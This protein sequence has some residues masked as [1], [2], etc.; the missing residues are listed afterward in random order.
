MRDDSYQC[1][2]RLYVYEL[3]DTYRDRLKHAGRGVG[4]PLEPLRKLRKQLSG[5]PQGV[6]LWDSQQYQLG[7]LLHERS[8]SYRCRTHDPA[9]A[10]LFFIPAFNADLLHGPLIGEPWRRRGRGASISDEHSDLLF[11]RLRAVRSSGSNESVFEA[12]GGAN[13][14][15]LNERLGADFENRPFAELAFDD[16]R[17]GST[18]RLAHEEYTEAWK[19]LPWPGYRAVPSLYHSIPFSS[20]VHLDSNAR[21]VPW[22]HVRGQRRPVLVGAAFG[23]D[24][25]AKDAVK[26][27]RALHR[28]CM[29]HAALCEFKL[30]EGMHAEIGQQRLLTIYNLYWRA[31]FCLMPPGDAISRKG[32]VDSLLLGCI[33]VHFYEAQLKLWPWHWGGWHVNATVLLDAGAVL[34]GKLDVTAHLAGI[35]AAQVATLRD[36]IEAHGQVLQ[37]S[38]VETKLLPPGLLPSPIAGD[39]FDAVLAG[40]KSDAH[41][42]TGPCYICLTDTEHCT[43]FAFTPSRAGVWAESKSPGAATKGHARMRVQQRLPL[44]GYCN[45]TETGPA[46]CSTASQGSFRMAENEGQTACFELCMRCERCH[47][48]SYSVLWQDCGWFASCD[49]AR[50]RKDVNGFETLAVQRSRRPT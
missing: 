19:H 27:R 5:F 50:L 49:L 45:K 46:S 48:I 22:A 32:T 21:G 3:P 20:A 9:L 44:Q 1:R 17:L 26:L 7:R 18:I 31:T 4:L 10:D 2:P 28:S 16:V 36:T 15:V 6:N 12:R 43:N 30:P 23:L 34:A 47:Y 24:H 35:A 25:G 29:A 33:P 41:H 40:A 39:A 8:L 37:Y 42:R 14:F 13:H 11:D 38:A